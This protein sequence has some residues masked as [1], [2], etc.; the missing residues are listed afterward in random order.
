MTDGFKRIMITLCVL[1]ADLALQPRT[2][3]HA[4]VDPGTTAPDAPR[5]PPPVTGQNSDPAAS[6]A[7]DSPVLPA[8]VSEPERA[9][10]EVSGLV[11]A[12]DPEESGGRRAARIALYPIR[13][14]WFVVWAPIRG[15]AWAYDRFAVPTRLR[16]WFFSEDGRVGLFPV[17]SYQNGFGVG[18]G[19]RFV[20]RDLFA[21]RA[22]LRV[23]ATYGGEVLQSYTAKYR[24]GRLLGRH[25]ELEVAAG[26]QTFPRNR[27]FG[28]GN[29][30]RLD[31]DELDPDEP[32]PP[33]LPMNVDALNDPTA[34]DTRYYYDAFTAE[35]TLAAKLPGP[36]R[37]RANG[38]YRLRHFEVDP[39]GDEDD[40]PIGAVYDVTKLVGFP[41]DLSNIYVE[42]SLV[43]DT[44]RQDRFDLSRATP[45][46]GWYVTGKLGYA[47]GLSDDPSEYWRWGVDVQRYLDLF[48]GDRILV[49]RAT[50]EGVTGSLADVPFIDLPKLG[51]P[52][53]LRG[54]QQDRFRDRQAGM[55]SAEY[56]WGVDRNVSAFVFTDVG[57]VWR[58]YDDFADTE[59]GDL[60]VGFGGGLQ[61]HSM[62]SFLARLMLAGS[63][64]GDFLF[65]FSFDPLYDKARE[66]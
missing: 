53:L 65:L 54:Y 56:Q 16:R 29:G 19:A 8:A 34:V 63:K 11:E 37:L 50:L 17:A 24:S 26:F 32:R 15:L 33:G 4:Q 3:A 2:L 21:E 27:F 14:L 36:F 1:A 42:A 55:A 64:D 30:D 25:A 60:R 6:G 40:I 13:G 22:R 49:L 20:L 18:G 12:R 44:L 31:F 41:E 28:I 23:T 43:V 62:K 45:S 46:A 38:G 48:R 5:D 47:Q 7:G 66:Q 59:L 52:V 9:L 57:R 58:G 39:G 10:G 51:G 35:A 61:L